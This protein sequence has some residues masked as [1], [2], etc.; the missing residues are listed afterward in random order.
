M[1]TTNSLYIL[2]T[3]TSTED[4]PVGAIGMS[5]TS[6]LQ[7]AMRVTKDGGPASSRPCLLNTPAH[8][9]M[10]IGSSANKPTIIENQ[11]VQGQYGQTNVHQAFLPLPSVLLL[12][13]ESK[14]D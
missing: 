6:R 7:L 3:A 12:V 10:T 4:S 13:T 11:P 2:Y 14:G 1:L 8:F 9:G 5:T